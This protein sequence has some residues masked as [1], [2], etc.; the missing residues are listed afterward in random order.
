ME[1]KLGM[2]EHYKGNRYD[3]IGVA[4][5]TETHEELVVYKALYGDG[6]IWVRPRVMFMETVEVDGTVRPR[7]EF[8]DGSSE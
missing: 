3:V 8:I 1:M 4:R 2:Y 6:Q 7:F 5:H